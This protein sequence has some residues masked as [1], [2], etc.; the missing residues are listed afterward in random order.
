MNGELYLKDIMHLVSQA[1]MVPAMVILVVLLVFTV[2][3]IGSLIVEIITERRH[4]KQ[5][6]PRDVN[7]VHDAPF[8][9]VVNVIESTGLLKSQ[10]E[11][12]AMVARNMGLPDAD[13][14]SLA[15]AEIARVD[16][17]HQRMV[18]QTDLVTKIGPMMGLICTL[19]PLGPGIVAMGQGEVDQL[20]SSLLIAFD[21]TVAGLVAAVVAMIISSIRKRWYAQYMVAM[22]ALMSS[23]LE[24]A[25]QARES[26]IV[27]PHG[28]TG[29]E[30]AGLPVDEG[31]YSWP[32]MGEGAKVPVTAMVATDDMRPVPAQAEG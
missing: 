9:A 25:D 2:F 1:L 11:A 4:F 6:T 15:K 24:K 5:N 12:L 14:F 21:G 30:R 19:I 28:Y 27:L 16:D 10:K 20:A 13:L 3:C 32:P 22:E 18:R 7:A 29:P 17:R 31:A 23:L 8:D 26:G